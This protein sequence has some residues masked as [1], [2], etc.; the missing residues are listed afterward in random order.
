[1][2]SKKCVYCDKNLR[3]IGNAR[4]NGKLHNDWE[5]RKYHK[6]CKNIHD[7]FLSVVTFT[8]C[9]FCRAVK[10]NESKSSICDLEQVYETHKKKYE[11][12][13]KTKYICN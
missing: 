13:F 2:E 3:P 9:N 6:K 1:M 5:S 4:K 10:N 7:G 8:Y 11:K 12:D